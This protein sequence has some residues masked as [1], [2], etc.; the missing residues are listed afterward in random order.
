MEKFKILVN[1]Y[2][3]T[4]PL[5][6]NGNGG[7]GAVG[8]CRYK[9]TRSWIYETVDRCKVRLIGCVKSRTKVKKN[10]WVNDLKN[11]YICSSRQNGTSPSTKNTVGREL[12]ENI[13]PNTKIIL[14]D[15]QIKQ[16]QSGFTDYYPSFYMSLEKYIS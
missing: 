7:F 8:G 6:E 11:D 16:R 4:G 3:F 1:Q 2:G 12:N 5:G 13:Q 9:C 14:S 10:E 15:Y